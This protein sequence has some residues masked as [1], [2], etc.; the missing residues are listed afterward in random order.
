VSL[1]PS[2]TEIVHALGC[3]DRL[4]GV[5]HECDHP[6]S[7]RR[8]PVLTRS[9][10]PVEASSLEIDAAV[11]S[12]GGGLYEIDE[13]RLA[14][15]EPDLILTQEQCDVCAVDERV[16][17]RIAT[18]LP[19]PCA[20]ESVNP[21]DLAS[22]HEVFRRVGE[23]LG[24][25][26]AAESLVAT[27]ERTTEEIRRRLAACEQVR[28][29]FLEW[30]EPP[31]IAGH[32]IPELIAAAGG[33]ELL[34]EA[35][36]PSRRTTWEAITKADPHVILLAPCGFSLRK[37]QAELTVLRARAECRALRA[38]RTGRV[39]LFDGSAFFSRPGPRLEASLRQAAA[40]LHPDRFPE[41]AVHWVVG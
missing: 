37:A 15:L 19:R 32:W 16:V 5:S 11:S 7:V 24:A 26:D 33:I 40:A 23:L 41:V 4:V 25:A 29:V 22:V 39:A 6:A 12:V 35:G 30:L 34:G 28:T 9:K 10:I 2:L 3:G 13:A 21:I 36:K 17:R 18:G 1:L 27:H 14:E 20:V 38:V 31:F 8:L